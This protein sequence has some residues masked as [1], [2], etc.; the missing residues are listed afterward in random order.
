MSLVADP[1]L[2]TAP[3]ICLT[4]RFNSPP[5][6]SPSSPAAHLHRFISSL[7]GIQIRKHC[8]E[9]TQKNF[10][11]REAWLCVL[12]GTKALAV[13]LVT[14]T[15]ILR[16]NLRD[17]WMEGMGGAAIADMLKENYYITGGCTGHSSMHTLSPPF[18]SLLLTFFLQKVPAHSH[19]YATLTQIIC[20]STW[21]YVVK[22]T[23]QEPGEGLLC[24][25]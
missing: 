8:T 23:V 14:N 3:F 11:L 21:C 6:P 24:I 20:H 16:L 25:L 12:Q 4:H 22:S 18:L 15:S 1:R 17:N 2:H 10:T 19:S 5:G 9:Q 13:P 7:T